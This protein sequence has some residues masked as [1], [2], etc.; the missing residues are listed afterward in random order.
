MKIQSIKFNKSK[1]VARVMLVILLVASAVS[2]FGCY[3]GSMVNREWVVETYNEF[4]EEII[5]FNSIND[6]SVN[7]YISFDLDE[8]EDILTRMYHFYVLANT[9]KTNK[10]GVCDKS[11]DSMVTSSTFHLKSDTKNSA[12]SEY[13]YQIACYTV[14]NIT[15]N[16]SENDKIEINKGFTKDG[17][18][19]PTEECWQI[20][21]DRHFL[22]SIY[23]YNYGYE[24][25]AARRIAYLTYQ[26][27]YHY[28]IFIN[29]EKYV[30]IHISSAEE[31]NDEKLEE[32]INMLSDS[33]VIINTE[34]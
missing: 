5:K 22:E 13:P 25:D 30:C 21:E 6:G 2:L 4:E 32:I 29:G 10:F 7:I 15:Q 1:L 11:C 14:R 9:A 19:L 28:E 27:T 12:N 23:E 24:H 18:E 3:F 16:L 8:N 34:G 26:N 33:M 20:S 17:E 31:L